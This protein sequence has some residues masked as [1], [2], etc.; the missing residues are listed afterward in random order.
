[1]L[2][3]VIITVHKITDHTDHGIRIGWGGPQAAEL[4]V[5]AL[6]CV[7]KGVFGARPDQML[8]EGLMPCHEWQSCFRLKPAG[9]CGGKTKHIFSCLCPPSNSGWTR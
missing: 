8:T 2:A 7:G 5:C 6:V 3:G 4:A 9:I 1:M